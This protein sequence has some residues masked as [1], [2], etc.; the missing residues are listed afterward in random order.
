MKSLRTIINAG[1]GFFLLL[2]HCKIFNPDIVFKNKRVAIIGSADSALQEQNGEYLNGFDIVIR[3]NKALV[4][5]VPQNEDKIGMKTDILFHSFYENDASGGGMLDFEVFKS[6]GVNFVVN[7]INTLKGKR[8][9]FNFYKKYRNKC[10]T[11]LLSKKYYSEMESLFGS[12]RPTIGFAAIYAVLKSP[13]KEVFITG[14]TFFRTPYA[15]GYRDALID[16]K[17]NRS[18]IAQQAL[19][20]PDLEFTSFIELLKSTANKKILMDAALTKIVG[21]KQK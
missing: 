12:L 1:K 14:F 10:E 16:I 19:H 9:N 15:K 5:W 6:H 8:L 18:Y 7:P 2:G 4:K 13:C 11:Y 17:A 21:A 3:I 20:D